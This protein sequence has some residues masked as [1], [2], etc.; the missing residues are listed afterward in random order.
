[1]IIIGEQ[2]R[3]RQHRTGLLNV[4]NSRLNAQRYRQAAMRPSSSRLDP[5]LRDTTELA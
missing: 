4:Q 5:E 1:M 3:D 2:G